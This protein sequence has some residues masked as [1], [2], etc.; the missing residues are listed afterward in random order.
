MVKY[1]VIGCTL[2]LV[3]EHVVQKHDDGKQLSN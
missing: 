3:I 1:D 2:V